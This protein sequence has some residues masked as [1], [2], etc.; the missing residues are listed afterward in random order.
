MQN[1]E[2][3]AKGKNLYLQRGAASEPGIHSGT[4]R[5]EGADHGANISS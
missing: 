1:S 4:K 5:K 3:M 2:L